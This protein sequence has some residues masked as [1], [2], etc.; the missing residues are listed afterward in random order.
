MAPPVPDALGFG[1]LDAVNIIGHSPAA[2]T[3]APRS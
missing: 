3:I 1:V 2:V